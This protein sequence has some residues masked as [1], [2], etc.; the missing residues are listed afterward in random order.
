ML[1]RLRPAVLGGGQTGSLLESGT[2]AVA[3]S[4]RIE[5]NAGPV[6]FTVIGEAEQEIDTGLSVDVVVRAEPSGEGTAT[7]V[8]IV[9]SA[10]ANFPEGSDGSIDIGLTADAVLP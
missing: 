4:V 7:A 6:T 2:V 1:D 8:L 9:T 3:F 10:A 5:D